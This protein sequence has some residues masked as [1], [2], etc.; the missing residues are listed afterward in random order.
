MKAKNSSHTFASEMSSNESINQ[1]G[2]IPPT[3]PRV[4]CGPGRLQPV[5]VPSQLR[6]PHPL[7]PLR[8]AQPTLQPLQPAPATGSG[9]TTC[10]R[11]RRIV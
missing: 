2:E 9:C 5:L 3:L 4:G 8:Q 11:C 6:N 1:R 7:A 10:N